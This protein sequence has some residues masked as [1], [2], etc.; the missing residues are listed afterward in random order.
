[1]LRQLPLLVCGGDIGRRLQNRAA[2]TAAGRW[3]ER[4]Y[5]VAGGGSSFT[6]GLVYR[7]F[8]CSSWL[9]EV[10]SDCRAFRPFRRGAAAA[11]PARGRAGRAGAAL[12]AAYGAVQGAGGRQ[13]APRSPSRLRT[14]PPRSCAPT[15]TLACVYKTVLSYRNQSLR[16]GCGVVEH[17]EVN[18]RG[19]IRPYKECLLSCYCCPWDACKGL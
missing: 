14:R 5:E 3:G 7:R 15:Q 6:S 18:G 12:A 2:H 1:M 11:L 8:G 16:G 19:L 10:P 17:V 4:D 13:P 9:S